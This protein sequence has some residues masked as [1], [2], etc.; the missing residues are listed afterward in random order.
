MNDEEAARFYEDPEH[1]K[2]A[3]P[4]VARRIR[5]GVRDLRYE[6]LSCGPQTQTVNTGSMPYWQRNPE[7]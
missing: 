7:A 5:P 1:L 2:T 6:P 3:G 4:W